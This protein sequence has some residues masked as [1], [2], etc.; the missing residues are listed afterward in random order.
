MIHMLTLTPFAFVRY[1][2]YIVTGYGIIIA[3]AVYYTVWIWILPR[4][5]GYRMRQEL[6]DLGNGAQSHRLLKIDV[7]DLPQW[8]ATHDAVGARVE[9]VGESI[10]T[11]SLREKASSVDTGVKS[12]L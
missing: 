9:P 1:A 3:C 5:K 6:V 8:D 10:E 4:W 12:A 11:M 7:K 2:T